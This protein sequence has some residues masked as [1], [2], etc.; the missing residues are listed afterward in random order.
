MKQLKPTD[1]PIKIQKE[2]SALN[3]K[4]NSADE[5]YFLFSL[6]EETKSKM[7]DLCERNSILLGK[8][9]RVSQMLPP[10]PSPPSPVQEPVRNRERRYEERE[11]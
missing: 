3:Y 5:N 7:N 1:R 8:D 6:N 10:P 9:G 11:D 2:L 4:F